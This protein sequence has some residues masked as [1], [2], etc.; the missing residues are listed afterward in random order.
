[1][2]VRLLLHW[3]HL[4]PHS[5]LTSSITVSFFSS[6]SKYSVILCCRVNYSYTPLESCMIA[7]PASFMEV[8]VLRI[9]LLVM[10]G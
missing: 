6:A 7:T 3:W 8:M 1:M 9:A 10:E 5:S 4:Q 2:Q